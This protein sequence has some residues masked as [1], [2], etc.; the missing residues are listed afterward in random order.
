[1]AGSGGVAR[2]KPRV[3]AVLAAPEGRATTY[4]TMA[5]AGSR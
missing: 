5:R 2:F 1:M 4:G 3:L